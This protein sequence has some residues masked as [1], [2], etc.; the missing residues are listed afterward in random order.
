MPVIEDVKVNEDTVPFKEFKGILGIQTE[1]GLSGGIDVETHSIVLGTVAIS[2]YT[3]TDEK[4][5]IKSSLEFTDDFEYK[6]NKL[7]IR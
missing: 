3:E 1:G 2:G 6:G 5:N 4:V 7:S